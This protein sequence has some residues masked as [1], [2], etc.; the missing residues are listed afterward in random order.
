M[1]NW[2]RKTAV[3]FYKDRKLKY[4]SAYTRIYIVCLILS[5]K[6]ILSARSIISCIFR[7]KY[8]IL[9]NFG[10]LFAA[11]RGLLDWCSTKAGIL[12]KAVLK[13]NSSP[14]FIKIFEKQLWRSLS[15]VK[16]KPN[17]C[18]FIKK[19]FPLQVFPKGLLYDRCTFFNL[20]DVEMLKK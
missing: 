13:C 19:W 18:N 17:T 5:L 9:E 14:I 1:A 15:L 3:Q 20:V 10:L 6:S 12:Q 11:A 2:Q 16:L 4:D 7:G 8:N